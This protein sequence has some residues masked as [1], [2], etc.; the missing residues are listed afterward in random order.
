MTKVTSIDG[1]IRIKASAGTVFRLMTDADVLLKVS[2]GVKRFWLEGDE[3][4]G[5]GSSIAF[6]MKKPLPGST[7]GLT[8]ILMFRAAGVKPTPGPV[9]RIRVT[10][11]EPNK[12]L[13]Y[14]ANHNG[15]LVMGSRDIIATA[16]G[17]ELH[18]TVSIAWSNP[19]AG[20]LKAPFFRLFGRMKDAAELR[21]LKKIC[22][23]A[24]RAGTR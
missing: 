11:Y 10:A 20:F 19:A 23:A 9:L 8:G 14:E 2:P 18:S 12:R 17:V 5:V 6:E 16:G 21:R 22:E 4:Y 7:Y 15:H 13:A 1:S 24:E 3:P